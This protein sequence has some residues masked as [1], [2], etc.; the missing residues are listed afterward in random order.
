LPSDS[1]TKASGEGALS[2]LDA[3][4]LARSA[5]LEKRRCVVSIEEEKKEFLISIQ[6]FAWVNNSW[7]IDCWSHTT[8]KLIRIPIGLIKGCEGLNDPA[9]T[10]GPAPLSDRWDE[11]QDRGVSYQYKDNLLEIEKWLSRE[12]QRLAQ[13][14]EEATKEEAAARRIKP[15]GKSGSKRYP[16]KAGE[17]WLDLGF[18]VDREAGLPQRMVSALDGLIKEK[19]KTNSSRISIPL[20]DGKPHNL[21]DKGECV[22]FP[23][24]REVNVYEGLQVVAQSSGDRVTGTIVSVA[25]DH[26]FV[27]FEGKGHSS[28]TDCIIRVDDTKLDERLKAQI[29]K[30]AHEAAEGFNLSLS[31]SAL[32]AKEIQRID[33]KTPAKFSPSLNTSQKRAIENGLKKSVSYIW[34]PPGTGKT[35]TLG[36]L[37][38]IL[39][40]QGEKVAICSH[41]NQAVD[42]LLL[43]LCETLGKA[44]RALLDGHVVRLGRAEHQQLAAEWENL[45]SVP[46]IADRKGRELIEEREKLEA[47]IEPL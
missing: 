39:Y 24:D 46:A 35:F 37:T 1:P 41:S 6:R 4:E 5:L 28:I 42:Q 32:T 47:Q 9:E 27:A 31:K 33:R 43:K 2:I 10:L 38:R 30:F 16:S 26:I 11:D 29:L 40:E 36:E 44:H 14:E 13:I 12:K 34:G 7:S 45:I 21:P 19:V 15:I 8:G 23:L 3:M 20:S 18:S 22:R 17:H 25:S